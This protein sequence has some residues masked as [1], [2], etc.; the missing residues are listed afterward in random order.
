MKSF[1]ALSLVESL[2]TLMIL[3]L[4]SGILIWMI[5]LAKTS[6][7]SSKNRTYLRQD[8][9]I[10]TTAMVRELQE[11]KIKSITV[12]NQGVKSFS[13]ISARNASGVF[14]TDTSG[15]PVWQNVDGTWRFIIYYIPANTTV[16]MKKEV[17]KT[18]GDALTSA[19]L[20]S[21]CD[22]KGKKLSS[23]VNDL[24]LTLPATQKDK[25]IDLSVTFQSKSN[26]GKID[27][28]TFQSR[29]FISN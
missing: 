3:S 18:T 17:L 24:S 5:L 12:I 15:A 10:I 11:S 14:V 6:M 21:F 2:I 22:G 29:I 19:D 28:M 8:M 20:L 16:L 7:E 27:N 26:I 23:M 4:L 13:F 9:Q 1:K 25:Y